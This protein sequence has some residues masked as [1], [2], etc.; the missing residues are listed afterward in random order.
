MAESLANLFIFYTGL[1]LFLLAAFAGFF[2]MFRFGKNH[3]GYTMGLFYVSSTLC[4]LA[5]AGY[6]LNEIVWKNRVALYGLTVLPGYLSCSV[7]ASQSIIYLCLFFKL[8]Q[9]AEDDSLRKEKISIILAS[10]FI[11]GFPLSF[12]I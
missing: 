1:I 12:I 6:F 3:G 7:A 4:L 5:R 2:N 10:V 11:I 8:S 9:Q